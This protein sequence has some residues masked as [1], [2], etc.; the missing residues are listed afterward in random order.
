IDAKTRAWL[1]WV[2]EYISPKIEMD[3]SYFYK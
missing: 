1:D 3:A 2:E